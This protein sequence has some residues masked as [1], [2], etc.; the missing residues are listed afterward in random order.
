MADLTASDFVFSVR[1]KRL[2]GKRKHFQGTL[3]FGDGVLMYPIGGIPA[4]LPHIYGFVS[5]LDFITL[6]DPDHSGGL[7]WKYDKD[8]NKLVAYQ[9]GGTSPTGAISSDSAGTPSGALSM[10]S[11]GTPTG[12][13]SMESG[14]TPSGTNSNESGGTPAG[15]NSAPTISTGADAGTDTVKIDS[16]ALVSVN[17]PETGVTGVQAPVFTGAVL[18]DHTHTFAGDPLADHDHDFV[19]DPLADHGHPFTGDPM[20]SH[21]HTFTGDAVGATELVEFGNVALPIQTMYVEAMGW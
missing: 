9:A 7:V 17:G 2:S 6:V 19:G 15:T 1:K 16:G 13:L 3:T 10:E 8:N 14:G 4:P 11:G 18:A 20:S 21:G 5:F 12:A